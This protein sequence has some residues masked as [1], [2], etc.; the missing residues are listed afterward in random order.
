MV[1][2][3][4]VKTM[5]GSNES[6]VDWRATKA[7]VEQRK[8]ERGKG[9]EEEERRGEK[10]VGVSVSEYMHLQ[11]KHRYMSPQREHYGRCRVLRTLYKRMLVDLTSVLY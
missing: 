9:K 3:G 1:G 7:G 11:H 10:C 5:V 2:W 8:R 6:Y 4:A